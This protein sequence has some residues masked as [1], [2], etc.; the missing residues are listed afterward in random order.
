[1]RSAATSLLLYASRP[2]FIK[3]NELPHTMESKIRINQAKVLDVMRVGGKRS[4]CSF[5]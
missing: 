2:R 1:M 5:L 4:K 3:I